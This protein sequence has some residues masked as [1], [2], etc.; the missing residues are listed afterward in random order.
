MDAAH[1]PPGP[2]N[3]E[4]LQEALRAFGASPSG[5]PTSEMAALAQRMG[6]TASPPVE[7][8]AFAGMQYVLIRLHEQD[9]AFPAPHV[10]GVERVTEVTPVPNT[11]AWVLGIANLRGAI[12]SVVDLRAFLGIAPAQ[13]T[14]PPASWSPARKRCLSVFWW[15]AS[16]NFACC[17]MSI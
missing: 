3:P 15:T 5:A 14:R 9:I 17:V 7:G 2:V 11:V 13:W 8:A 12:T 1:R 4:A 6:L 10:I 16:P